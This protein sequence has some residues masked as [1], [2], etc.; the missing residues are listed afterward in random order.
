ML[1]VGFVAKQRRNGK[2]LGHGNRWWWRGAPHASGC[3]ADGERCCSSPISFHL[4]KSRTC[5][6]SSALRQH[7]YYTA[8]LYFLPEEPIMSRDECQ[9]KLAVD[10][11]S[12]Q[13][14]MLSPKCMLICSALSASTDAHQSAFLL[15]CLNIV[16]SW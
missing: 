3:S 11:N 16:S 14:E 5:C 12:S 4:N 9:N 2:H 13:G 1:N 15:L 10:I 6:C 7:T 8:N